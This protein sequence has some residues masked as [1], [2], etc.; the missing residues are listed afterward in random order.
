MGGL[1]FYASGPIIIVI[2]GKAPMR[3]KAETQIFIDNWCCGMTSVYSVSD[4]D[5]ILAPTLITYMIFK[6]LPFWYSISPCGWKLVFCWMSTTC[7]AFCWYCMYVHLTVRSVRCLI[8]SVLHTLGPWRSLTSNNLPR[9]SS[10]STVELEFESSSAR[11]QNLSDL[12]CTTTACRGNTGG[13][14]LRVLR[15]EYGSVEEK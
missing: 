14:P 8:L 2:N 5:L 11:V 3:E 6:S 10:Y 12:N 4:L 9:K 15:S 13:L 7:Q 1:G